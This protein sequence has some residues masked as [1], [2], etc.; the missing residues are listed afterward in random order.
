MRGFC[1]HDWHQ[2]TE[3]DLQHMALG[4]GDFEYAVWETMNLRPHPATALDEKIR[5]QK[6]ITDKAF[7]L[8]V[9][10][11]LIPYTEATFLALMDEIEAKGDGA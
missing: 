3:T 2:T 4:N 7:A 5:K 11:N 8:A 9:E 10:R 6:A 1:P